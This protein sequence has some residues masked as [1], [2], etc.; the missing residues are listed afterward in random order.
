MV[1]RVKPNYDFVCIGE[2]ATRRD[3]EM[4][5]DTIF[6]AVHVDC[7]TLGDYIVLYTHISYIELCVV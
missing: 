1:Y 3:G 5:A 7:C 6:S 4:R 2:L